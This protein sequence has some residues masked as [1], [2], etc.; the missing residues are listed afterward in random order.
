M[1]EFY[2]T[3]LYKIIPPFNI[4]HLT[5][6][7]LYHYPRFP[8]T[9]ILLMRNRISNVFVSYMAFCCS[10][11]GA[12]KI[13][14]PSTSP[15]SVENVKGKWYFNWREGSRKIGCFV[16]E[17]MLHLF[18]ASGT[19]TRTIVYENGQLCLYNILSLYLIGCIFSSYHASYYST[20]H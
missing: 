4:I 18:L 20:T 11:T 17:S 9:D 8:S 13:P 1:Q 16:R 12:T 14:R 10:R 19:S 15:A 3:S 5:K 7:S 6:W 2:S